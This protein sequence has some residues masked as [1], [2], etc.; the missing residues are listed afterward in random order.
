MFSFSKLL[1]C[2]N[3]RHNP[4]P[5]LNFGFHL[6]VQPKKLDEDKELFAFL[7]KVKIFVWTRFRLLAWWYL[8]RSYMDK[9]TYHH[10]H[11]KL[12]NELF[13]E[14]DNNSIHFYSRNRGARI[15]KSSH[16]RWVKKLRLYSLHSGVNIATFYTIILYTIISL[17]ILTPGVINLKCLS[18]YGVKIQ[19]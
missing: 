11:P 19:K 16:F 8:F 12:T 14:R 17:P 4:H 1:S 18:F 15:T 9:Y 10:Y 2:R 5:E 6:R 13:S 7:L 3:C